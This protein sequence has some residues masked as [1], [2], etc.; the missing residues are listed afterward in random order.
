MFN[1]YIVKPKRSHNENTQC[2]LHPIH[3]VLMM[4]KIQ[5]RDKYLGIIPI[6]VLLECVQVVLDDNPFY[7][8]RIC[9]LNG[10]YSFDIS[11]A[12]IIVEHLQHSDDSIHDSVDDTLAA[13]KYIP[14]ETVC[15]LRLTTSP[16]YSSIGL[17]INHAMYDGHVHAIFWQNLMSAYNK[18]GILPLKMENLDCIQTRS[19]NKQS[20]S[21]FLKRWNFIDIVKFAKEKNLTTN[22]K[23][24]SFV[25]PIDLVQ[26]WQ[27]VIGHQVTVT[28]ILTVMVMQYFS[29]LGDMKK[30]CIVPIN[31]RGKHPIYTSTSMGSCVL[32]AVYKT[33][34]FLM[35]IV[36]T[37]IDYHT[38]IVNNYLKRDG[39]AKDIEWLN[40]NE[41]NK[42]IGLLWGAPANIPSKIFSSYCCVTDCAK[43]VYQPTAFGHSVIDIQPLLVPNNG[44]L[45][46]IGSNYVV[47]LAIPVHNVEILQEKWSSLIDHITIQINK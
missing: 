4:S 33:P 18:R 14:F 25:V 26:T 46:K 36:Q 24:T 13:S 41:F 37:T 7:G 29:V 2:H 5:I 23:T 27:N 44:C 32:F 10:K 28:S 40:H 20:P 45:R 42:P 19:T 11:S 21:K 15:C 34:N 47:D 9:R 31:V 12:N 39:V 43:F 22:M 3:K 8:A 38:K 16:N 6:S 17:V 30:Y 35:N 1:T